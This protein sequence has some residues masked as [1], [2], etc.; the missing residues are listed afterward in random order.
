M[1][2]QLLDAIVYSLTLKDFQDNFCI[3]ELCPSLQFGE[4][5]ILITSFVFVDSFS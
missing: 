2:N 1:V 5:Q 4:N 3:D